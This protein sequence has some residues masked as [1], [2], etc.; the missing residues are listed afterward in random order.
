MAAL[1]GPLY[2]QHLWESNM[3]KGKRAGDIEAYRGERQRE[4]IREKKKK[5]EKTR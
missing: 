2:L 3:N 1:P 5:K 4:R